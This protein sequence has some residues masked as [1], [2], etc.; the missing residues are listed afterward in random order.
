MM[1]YVSNKIAKENLSKEIKYLGINANRLIFVEKLPRAEYLARYR[2][3]DLFLDTHPYNAGTTASDALRMGLPILTLNGN[4]FN[5][6]EAASII[7]AV[8]LPEMITKTN[9]EYES[10]AIELAENP[11]KYKVIKEK[12]AKNLHNAPL[13][14]TPLFVKNLESTYEIMYEK[15]HQG[16]EPDHIYLND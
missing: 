1:I 16:L 12:L 10:L 14:N 3:A 7:S 9:E 6:R 13:F 5:S 11:K 4:S 15:Y 2:L 8:N